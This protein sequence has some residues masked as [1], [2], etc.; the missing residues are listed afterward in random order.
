M[1]KILVILGGG[2]ATIAGLAQY[3]PLTD[4]QLGIRYR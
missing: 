1:D 4:S 2:V 3:E